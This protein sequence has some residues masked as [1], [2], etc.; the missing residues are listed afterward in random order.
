M[1]AVDLVIQV[2][3]PKSVARGLQRARP[4]RSRAR[5]WSPKGRI[6]PPKFRADLLESAVVARAMRAGEI[7]E[8]RIPRRNP[9]YALAQ[10][11][12]AI[13]ADEEI[14]VADLHALVRRAAPYAEL[15][16]AQL[17]NVLDMLAGRYPSD[18]FAEL[19]PRLIWD[20][21]R[22]LAHREGPDA[23]RSPT[24][25]R[26]PTAACSASSWW[27]AVAGSA[28]STRR[29]STRRAPARR[30]CSAPR[31]GG[32][33]RSRRRPVCSSRPRRGSRR[34]AVL[35]R[36]GGRP[37]LRA[38]AAHRRGV[39]AR[40]RGARRRASARAATRGATSSTPGRRATCSASCAM[41]RPATGALPS[42]R[43]VVVERFRDEIGDWRVCVLAVRRAGAR[44]LGDGHHRTAAHDARH[45][46]RSI[47]SDDGSPCTFRTRSRRP[48]AELAA[49][50]RRDRGARG[51]RA[52]RDGALRR[53]LPRE[54]RTG[55]AAPTPQPR[56]AYP[57]WQQRLEAQPL[58]EVA[59]GHASFPIMLETYRECLQDVFDLPS[60]RGVL[61]GL[62]RRRIDLVE[63]ERP[64]RLALQP[65][66]PLRLHRHVHVRGRH[67]PGGAARAGALA[68]PRP[69][70]RA[71]RAGGAARPSRP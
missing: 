24:P 3:S 6:F 66:A 42:D 52:R 8:T 4:R 62:Q 67:A 55:A 28:S 11:I 18:A 56:P 27:A 58:L 63:V 2:E 44:P 5:S 59:R 70:R 30:S 45:R 61:A 47:W 53:P 40:A 35:E 22:T 23:S 14:T 10:Q 26:S 50:P 1:G 33:R 25:G 51:R 38:R 69:A 68:R 31:P 21:R 39:S 65:I 20:Q 41:R 64:A 15:S 49:R 19:R 46:T 54:R 34:R 48:G 13:C 17:E 7:E 32:S 29:W 37:S 36:R 71:A 16:R 9:L 43:T 12:V 60:L 57:A